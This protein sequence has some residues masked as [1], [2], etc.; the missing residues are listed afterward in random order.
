MAPVETPVDPGRDGE[1][2]ARALSRPDRLRGRIDAVAVA[3][4]TEAA[5]AGLDRAR[6][7]SD[8]KR[9]RTATP[10]RGVAGPLLDMALGGRAIRPS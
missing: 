8:G 3:G 7:T 9:G 10:F 6:E 4:G 1:P 2:E 5:V